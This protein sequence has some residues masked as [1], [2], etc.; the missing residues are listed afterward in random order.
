MLQH[1]SLAIKLRRVQLLQPPSQPECQRAFVSL[2]FQGG[3]GP[4]GTCLGQKQAETPGRV[5]ACSHALTLGPICGHSP[6]ANLS[7]H[8]VPHSQGNQV[9]GDGVL[10]LED[11]GII[12]LLL[13]GCGAHHG[14]ETL[15][16]LQ[17]S[18]KRPSDLRGTEWGFSQ[19]DGD[20]AMNPLG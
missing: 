19:P 7:R 15:G 17:T 9:R 2:L 1:E 13:P 14:R 18:P 12:F 20:T 6:R 10:H 11:K 3:K 8:N 16:N 5:A 4:L